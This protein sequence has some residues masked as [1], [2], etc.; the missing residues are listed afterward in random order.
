MALRVNTQLFRNL[1]RRRSAT[2]SVLHA[3]KPVYTLNVSENGNR[4]HLTEMLLKFEEV[5]DFADKEMHLIPFEIQVDI[6]GIISLLHSMLLK[7]TSMLN[8]TCGNVV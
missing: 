7:V 3:T 5:L 1:P 6:N 2:C 4:L 8:R